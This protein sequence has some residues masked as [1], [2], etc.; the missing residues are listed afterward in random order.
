MLPVW[1]LSYMEY[2]INLYLMCFPYNVLCGIELFADNIGSGIVN[3]FHK[4]RKDEL[5]FMATNFL[6]R[7][8]WE[9]SG[10]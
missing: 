4:L 10:V 6:F 8:K 2:E 9:K 5:H 1:H 7:R 3:T